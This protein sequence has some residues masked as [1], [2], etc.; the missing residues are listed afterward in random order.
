[1]RIVPMPRVGI[2]NRYPLVYDF[3]RN[4]GARYAQV[5]RW[6][7]HTLPHRGNGHW[8]GWRYH[9]TYNKAVDEL[10]AELDVPSYNGLDVA[11]LDRERYTVLALQGVVHV[12][13]RDEDDG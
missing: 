8:D 10:L 12:N 6:M 11:I 3:F 1:M 9:A 7:E 13:R 4:S 2:I 5:Y